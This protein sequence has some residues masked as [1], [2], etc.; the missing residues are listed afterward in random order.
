[1]FDI[2]KLERRIETLELD[3]RERLC[4]KGKHEWEMKKGYQGVYLGCKYCSAEKENK[5]P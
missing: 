4:E 3:Y 1:M 2:K 5:K